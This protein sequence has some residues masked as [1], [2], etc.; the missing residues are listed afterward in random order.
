MLCPECLK[1]GSAFGICTG[2]RRG[3][4]EFAGKGCTT[5]L[6]QTSNPQLRIC[7]NCSAKR[8]LCQ[9]CGKPLTDTETKDD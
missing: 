4:C 9:K 3:T 8:K 5:R 7:A 6:N 1:P 2:V